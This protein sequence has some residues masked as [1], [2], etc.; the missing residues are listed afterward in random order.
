MV[1]E[2]KLDSRLKMYFYSAHD[3]NIVGILR[4]FNITLES[5]S[6]YSSLVLIELHESKGNEFF[7][8]VIKF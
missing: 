5:F 8:K 1:T 7:V 6:T 3:S 2:K 4:S